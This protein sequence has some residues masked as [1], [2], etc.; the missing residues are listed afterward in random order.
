ME[1]RSAHM[2]ITSREMTKN[3]AR[4]LR[5]LREKLRLNRIG[6]SRRLGVDK[7]SYTRNEDGDT[8]PGL[9]SL[10][11]MH[12]QWNVSMDWFMFGKGSMY[13]KDYDAE[14]ARANS[15]VKE[16]EEELEQLAGHASARPEI[17]ELLESM[18][19]DPQLRHEI[20]VCFYKYKKENKNTGEKS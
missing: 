17:K 11:T 13:L 5:V 9:K 3:A 15:R 10:I 16:L 4:R 20:L 7:G 2:A 14:V 19:Q 18:N 1:K 6:M 8:F 12:E